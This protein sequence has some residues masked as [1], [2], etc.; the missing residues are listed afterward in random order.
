[1]QNSE[2]LEWLL[3]EGLE[4][5]S[6]SITDV[7]A[8]VKYNVKPGEIPRELIHVFKGASSKYPNIPWTVLAAIAYR[9]SSFTSNCI[10]VYLPELGTRA[11]GMM[12]FLPETF[13]KFKVD[14]K[15]NGVVSPFDPNDAIYSAANYLNY[16]Y[17]RHLSQGLSS[18]NALRAAVYDYNHAWWYVD[19]V[20]SI[21]D[22]YSKKY[23]TVQSVRVHKCE[24]GLE[25]DRDI[26]AAINILHEGLRQLGVTA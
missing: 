22:T 11:V 14:A 8:A 9:E 23:N 15:G 24:C 6:F 17:Q 5:G 21:A 20:M 18:T 13:D 7:P 19:Q 26:N 12:Q 25:I 2:N 3:A 4:D 10:G 1:M 16:N